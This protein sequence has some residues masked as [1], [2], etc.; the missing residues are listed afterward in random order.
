M[1]RCFVIPIVVET[2]PAPAPQPE[3]PAS[4]PTTRKVATR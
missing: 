3:K 2:P 1:T 4:D